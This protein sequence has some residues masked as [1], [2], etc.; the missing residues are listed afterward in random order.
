[1][2]ASIVTAARTSRRSGGS[3]RRAYFGPEIGWFDVPVV[4]RSDLQGEIVSG[5]VFVDEYDS[6]TVLPPGCSATLDRFGCIDIHV[7]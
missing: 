5:P 2:P 4:D 6:T 1:V 3:V 7:D